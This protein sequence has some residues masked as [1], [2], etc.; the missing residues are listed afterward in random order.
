MSVFREAEI[1]LGGKTYTVIPSN[2]L[3]RRIENEVSLARMAFNYERGEPQNSHLAFVLSKLISTD[4]TGFDMTEDKVMG[5][6]LEM[7][8]ATQLQGV[9]GAVFTILMPPPKKKDAAES[10]PSE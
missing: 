3:L 4:P 7:E 8:A 5:E 2:R 10:D 6:L 9:W 1:E